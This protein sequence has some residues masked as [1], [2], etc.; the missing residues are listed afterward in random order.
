MNETEALRRYQQT[1]DA[2]AFAQLVEHYQR[3]VWAACRRHLSEPADIEDAVQ[4]TFLRLARRSGDIQTSL[5]GWLHTCAVRVSLDLRRKQGRQERHQA[6]AYAQASQAPPPGAE[7]A[8]IRGELDAALEALDDPQRTLILRRFYEGMSQADLAR[9]AGVSEATMSRRVQAAVE[10]LRK[11]MKKRGV[12]APATPLVVLLATDAATAQVPAAV[13]AAAVQVGLSGVGVGAGAGASGAAGG[14][15]AASTAAPTAAAV[16]AGAGAGASM[17]VKLGVV[18]V[19]AVVLVVGAGAAI[20]TAIA[21]SGSSS[22]VAFTGTP[23]VEALLEVYRRNAAALN[24][25][26]ARGEI[27][28]QWDDPSGGV[29]GRQWS[30]RFEFFRHGDSVDAATYGIRRAGPGDEE[31]VVSHMRDIVHGFGAHYVHDGDGVP[32]FI[33]YWPDG[34]ELGE[35]RELAWIRLQGG[36]ALD[37]HFA[38]DSLN[39]AQ[40][41]RL[42]DSRLRPEMEPV[43]GYPCWVI[44]SA[45]PFGSYTVWLDPSAGCQPRRAV[46]RKDAEHRYQTRDRTVADVKYPVRSLESVEWELSDVQVEVVDGHALTTA[47]TLVERQNWSTGEQRFVR[48]CQRAVD[49]TPDFAAR[50]AFKIDVPEGTRVIHQG[51]SR[52]NG[53][54]DYTWVNGAPQHRRGPKAPETPTPPPPPEAP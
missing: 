3:L 42:S 22:T 11:L 8:A 23:S 51:F 14:V 43:D 36:E 13:T 12:L 29:V 48:R 47:A 32:D 30:T 45:G 1:G 21:P 50:G 40:V 54:F 31:Q 2:E 52:A 20:W 27:H 25:S 34:A 9:E 7:W 26:A 24:I 5:S 41:M 16:G 38:S 39:F 18:G 46:V 49:L 4:E 35:R 37:G 19:V 53:T 15:S 6:A 33:Y 17:A 10:Q 28:T 44:E